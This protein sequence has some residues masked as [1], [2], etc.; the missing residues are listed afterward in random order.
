MHITKIATSIATR[1]TSKTQSVNV[2]I[3][4]ISGNDVVLDLVADNDAIDWLYKNFASYCI[5]Q[6]TIVS[7]P[8]GP[9]KLIVRLSEIESFRKTLYIIELEQ[10]AFEETTAVISAKLIS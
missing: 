10:L 3:V 7:D 4:E 8:S 9:K 1:L 6:K 5:D 2:H